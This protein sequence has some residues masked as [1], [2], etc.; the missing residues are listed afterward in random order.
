MRTEAMI[1]MIKKTVREGLNCDRCIFDCAEEEEGFCLLI[2]VVKKLDTLQRGI[3]RAQKQMREAV[4]DLKDADRIECSHCR[5]YDV[6]KDDCN[7]DLYCMK[8]EKASCPCRH[9]IDMRN[10]EWRGFAGEGK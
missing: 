7:E 10:W 4:E 1:D 9:C 6:P 5:H 8:C 2:G 3:V